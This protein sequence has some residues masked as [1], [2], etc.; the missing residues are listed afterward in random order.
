M[1]DD[2]TY[3][4]I[5]YS[6]TSAA[7]FDDNENGVLPF[8]VPYFVN[9]YV[10]GRIVTTEG[11]AF[12]ESKLSTDKY[13]GENTSV[14]IPEFISVDNK[15]GTHSAYAIRKLS[16]ET[17]RGKSEIKSVLLSSYI[18]DIPNSA[19]AGCTSLED[20]CFIEPDTQ[21]YSFGKG[22][23]PAYDPSNPTAWTI[24]GEEPLKFMAE[25]DISTETL[26]GYS[27]FA[28]G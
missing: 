18:R 28:E 22:S 8:E 15:D 9:E 11:L 19:F 1:L 10:N 24:N 23:L 26:S 12:D 4:Y 21:Y 6:A 25:H 3:T 20:I 16:D 2:E 13:E 14:I 5:D 27:V 7:K 17:F